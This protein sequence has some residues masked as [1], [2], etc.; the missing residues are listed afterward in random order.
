MTKTKT[1]IDHVQKNTKKE[2]QGEQLVFSSYGSATTETKYQKFPLEWESPWAG[3]DKCKA[4]PQGQQ[5]GNRT[6]S[7]IRQKKTSRAEYMV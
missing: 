2:T 3:N 5:L 7:G 1:Y 6:G 4:N